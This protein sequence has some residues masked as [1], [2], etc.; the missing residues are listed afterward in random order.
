MPVFYAWYK[1]SIYK[2]LWNGC[3][4]SDAYGIYT[5]FATR[6][7]D[8]HHFFYDNSTEYCTNSGVTNAYDVLITCESVHF[9]N[10]TKYGQINYICWSCGEIAYN[11]PMNIL[12]TSFFGIKYVKRLVS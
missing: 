5:I 9:E 10:I 1:K 4:G 2:L 7:T 11:A 3:F 12:E 6:T 8:T